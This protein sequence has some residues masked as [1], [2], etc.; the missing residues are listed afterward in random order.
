MLMSGDWDM[1][2]PFFDTYMKVLPLASYR[3]NKYFGHPGAYFFETMEFWGGSP[4]YIYGWQEQRRKNEAKEGYPD[5][6]MH[7]YH[8]NGGLELS[9]MMLDYY[10]YT[11]DESFATEYL[12]PMADPV[13]TFFAEHYPRDASGQLHITPSQALESW[14]DVV[15]PTPEVAGLHYVLDGLLTLPQSLVSEEQRSDWQQLKSILPEIPTRE[16][17]GEPA[18][19]VG[20]AYSKVPKNH[21]NPELYPVFPYRLFGL[22]DPEGIAPAR[23]AFENRRVKNNTGWSQD[24]AQAALLGDTQTAAEMLLKRATGVHAQARFPAF[25]GPNFNWIPDQDH[26]GVLMI[27]LQAMLLQSYSDGSIAVLPA[28]PEEWNVDFRLRAYG[29]TVV[30]GSY[31]DGAWHTLETTPENQ[32]SRL[33]RMNDRCEV[34]P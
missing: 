17:H 15:N 32:K 11:K 30:T 13:L 22:F 31:E 10:R 19:W 29:D 8:F 20:D 18:L 5:H 33:A 7:R 24:E 6:L 2:K 21:E 4:E 1:L 16:I 14:Q 28:W 26:G 12:I 3:T 34:A 27:A 25:W 23:L 9:A